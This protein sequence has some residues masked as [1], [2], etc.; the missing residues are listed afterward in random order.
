MRSLSSGYL[1]ELSFTADHLAALRALGEFR[2]KQSLYFHQA[3]ET[4]KTLRQVAVVESTESSSRIE[5]VTVAPGRLEPLVLKRTDPRNRS[6][7][8]VAG[9][10]DALGLIHESARE[11]EFSANIVLQLHGMLYRYMPQRGGRWKSSPNEITET[12]AD[13]STRVRFVP[14]SPHLTPIQMDQLAEGYARA[15]D[16]HHQDSLVLVP[17]AI[18]DFL[19]I[20]PFTDGNGRVA[21]LLSLMLLYQADYEVGRYISLERI[22]EQS[23]ESYYETLE[24]SSAG[25]HE[26]R[27]DAMP[28]LEY[29]WG[30]LI[31]AYREFEER[32][33]RVRTVPGAKTEQ[34]RLAVSRRAQPF[35]ISEI[36]AECADV[37]RDMV[38][39]VLRQMREEGL[40]EVIGRG[41]GAKWR[42]IDSS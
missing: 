3:P 39:H 37:S 19:C 36:E 31:R 38:R 34:V 20:H 2:G 42:Q 27:H 23:K 32:V 14:T 7:Q 5:G 16:A 33:H 17:L 1:Q 29:F 28:W 35:A 13:G 41:R 30:T 15:V 6:E 25:W 10:R 40:I 11:M 22:I 12:Q 24:K 9:Y 26:G 21:R 8:E 18:L 4:L